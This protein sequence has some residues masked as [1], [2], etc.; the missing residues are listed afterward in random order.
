MTLQSSNLNLIPPKTTE[1][2]QGHTENIFKQITVLK[3]SDSRRL[4]VTSHIDKSLP[5]TYNLAYGTCN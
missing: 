3:K 1:N 2:K 5:Y 4:C